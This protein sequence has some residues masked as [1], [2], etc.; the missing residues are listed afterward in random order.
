M[1]AI[2]VAVLVYFLGGSVQFLISNKYRINFLLICNTLA[3]IFLVLP[4]FSVLIKGYSFDIFLKSNSLINDLIFRLDGISAFFLMIIAFLGLVGSFYAKGYLKS[5]I[6]KENLLPSHLFFFNLF[7]IS[8]ILVVLSQNAI[9]FL[10]SWEIMS[11]SSFFLLIFEDEKKEV[12]N[13]G[14]NYLIKMHVC[15]LF[16]IVGFIL[17]NLKTGSFDFLDYKNQFSDLIFVIMFIGF[18]IKAGIVPFYTWL[19]KAHPV[20]PSHISALMSGVMIKTG[21]YGILRML[22]LYEPS[23]KV[24]Y[25][26]LII[27]LLTAFFGILYSIA[28]RN[29]KKMLAYSSIEN[30]GII[31][32]AIAIGM[33]GM[34]YHNP[35]MMMFGFLGC[36]LHILN[37]SLFKSLLFMAAGVVYTKVHTKDME[38]LGGLIKK[39]PKTATMFLIGSIAISAIPPFNGFISEFLIYM[40]FLGSFNSLNHILTPCM[41]LAMGIL[42]F[43][44]AMALIAFTN[45]FSIVFLGNPRS[46]VVEHVDNDV[47]KTMLYPMLCLV[48]FIILIGTFPQYIINIIEFPLRE[49]V[50]VN[51]PYHLLINISRIN[52]MLIILFGVIWGVRYFLLKDKHVSSNITWGC[53]YENATAKV[54]YSANS[55][56]RPFLG[57]LTPFYVRELEF[58][59]IKELF[60]RSTYFK[61][62]IKDIFSVYFIEPVVKI[63]SWIVKRFYWI[64]SGKTQDYLLYGVIFLIMAIACLLGGKL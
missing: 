3:T 13:I 46:D 16:L 51:I 37:H 43:V 62:V 50:L 15:V 33:L 5:Y 18:G 21:I 48:M 25:L 34:C 9:F 26:V 14:I 58:Q 35:I 39:M 42:A 11:L 31:C 28:Q 29:Y 41:I 60:P 7:L 10:I 44:G 40:G 59:Q 17:L 54:Q 27:G 36:F 56:T 47:N 64:Q 23:L 61:S 45:A 20:A 1:E 63:S 19:P 22:T 57:F 49:F 6:E 52:V 53:G 38:K 30:I 2:F 4:V 8:M 24:A 55:F 12:R 32:I